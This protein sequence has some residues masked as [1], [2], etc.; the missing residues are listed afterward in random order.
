MSSTCEVN[1]A[2]CAP[3]SASKGAARHGDIRLAAVAQHLQRVAAH[4]VHLFQRQFHDLVRRGDLL[5]HAGAVVIDDAVG[6]DTGDFRAREHNQVGVI[7]RRAVLRDGVERDQ[8][9]P[10]GLGPVPCQRFVAAFRYRHIGDAVHA[11]EAQA[12]RG[13]QKRAV[14]LARAEIM[15]DLVMACDEGAH[16]RRALDPPVGGEH[17]V[18]DRRAVVVR[19]HPVARKDVVGAVLVPLHLRHRDAGFQQCGDKAVDFPSGAVQQFLRRYIRA[20]RLEDVAVLRL[21]IGKE[22]RG[23]H[24]EDMAGRLRRRHRPYIQMLVI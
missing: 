15:R 24:H 4:L 12:A 13:L 2:T 7:D 16:F 22:H 17:G 6:A 3:S 9:V 1:A 5:H 8:I 11:V 18:Q 10:R 23:P 20:A 21:G 19:R 14:V